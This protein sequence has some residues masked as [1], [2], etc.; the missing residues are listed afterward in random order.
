MHKKAS[1]EYN[2]VLLLL[3]RH[4]NSCIDVPRTLVPYIDWMASKNDELGGAVHVVVKFSFGPRSTI[5]INQS[6]LEC[7]STPHFNIILL[8]Y[9]KVTSIYYTLHT[10]SRIMWFSK[11][12]HYILLT[13]F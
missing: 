9:K 5:S 6:L 3:P 2:L 8:S 4:S 1:L 13:F 10:M 7:C 12:A 11:N